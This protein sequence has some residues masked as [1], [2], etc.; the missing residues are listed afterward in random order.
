MSRSLSVLQVVY[1]NTA[2]ASLKDADCLLIGAGTVRPPNFFR[3]VSL[4]FE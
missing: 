2:G 3:R 1:P 4:N